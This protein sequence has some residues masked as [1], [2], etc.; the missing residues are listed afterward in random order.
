[1]LGASSRD[2]RD[3]AYA[4][5][6][7]TG[8]PMPHSDHHSPSNPS[9]QSL[10]ADM[11][12]TLSEPFKWWWGLPRKGWLFWIMPPLVAYVLWVGWLTHGAQNPL[13]LGPLI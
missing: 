9:N 11:W 6:H 7:K 10:L 3:R 4:H 2:Q 1:M 13:V 8:E 5:H 12:Q